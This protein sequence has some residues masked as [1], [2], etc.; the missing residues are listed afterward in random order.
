MP[1]TSQ[2]SVMPRD[3][4]KRMHTGTMII[5]GLP[6]DT[7]CAFKSEC[8]RRGV[9]MRDAFIVFM[10]DYVSGSYFAPKQVGRPL[11]QPNRPNARSNKTYQKFVDA[12]N[13]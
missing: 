9:T 1:R 6:R 8:Y 7:K 10:R 11:D 13:K 2:I 4:T 12:H 3:K 5:Q